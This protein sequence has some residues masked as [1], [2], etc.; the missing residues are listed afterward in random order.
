MAN[1][2]D[3]INVYQGVIS[4][5]PSWKAIFISPYFQAIKSFIL[6]VLGG[7]ILGLF[8]WPI[9]KINQQRQSLNNQ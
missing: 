8:I 2:E 1:N 9:F 4:Q 6:N 3:D 7:T 5:L